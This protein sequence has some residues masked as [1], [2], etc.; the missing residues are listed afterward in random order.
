MP[1]QGSSISG[2]CSRPS[3]ICED[4]AVTTIEGSSLFWAI[5][6]TPGMLA[7]S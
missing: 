3:Q 2:R 7:T 1:S 6:D 5:K 4:F